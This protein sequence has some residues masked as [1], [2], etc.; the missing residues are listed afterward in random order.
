MER[1]LILHGLLR[2]TSDWMRSHFSRLFRSVSCHGKRVSWCSPDWRWL[3]DPLRTDLVLKMNWDTRQKQQVKWHQ[4]IWYLHPH[5]TLYIFS[6]VYVQVCI[7]LYICTYIRAY[8]PLDTRLVSLAQAPPPPPPS[9]SWFLFAYIYMTYALMYICIYVNINLY[10]C[11]YIYIH[12]HIYTFFDDETDFFESEFIFPLGV[13][14]PVFSPVRPL[15]STPFFLDFLI[16]WV[17]PSLWVPLVC[18]PY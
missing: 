5:N 14:P 9:P 18:C 1:G 11:I 7:N 3:M 15:N 13:F 2:P 17:P 4:Y 6:Y 16:S 10:I 8:V 12:I